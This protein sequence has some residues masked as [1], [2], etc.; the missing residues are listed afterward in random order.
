MDAVVI[1]FKDGATGAGIFYRLGAGA[2]AGVDAI[3]GVFV[4][5]AVRGTDQAAVASRAAANATAACMEIL[6]SP[7]RPPTLHSISA[8]APSLS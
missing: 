3:V 6:S 5:N 7:L 8:F 1:F 2:C 4:G